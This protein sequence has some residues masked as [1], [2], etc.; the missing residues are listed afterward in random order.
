MH[1]S[2]TSFPYS[3]YVIIC[4]CTFDFVIVSIFL[5]VIV[6]KYDFVIMYIFLFVIIS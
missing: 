3:D 5:F 1:C 4:L 2:P 6:F